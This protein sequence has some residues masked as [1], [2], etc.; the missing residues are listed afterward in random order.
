MSAVDAG[1]STRNSTESAPSPRLPE[2][3]ETFFN[4]SHDMFCVAGTDGYFKLV[5]PAFQRVLGYT[6]V[7]LLSQPF[8]E[9]VY[10]P[11]RAATMEEVE[12]LRTGQSSVMF[13]NRYYH[14]DRHLLWIQWNSTVHSDGLI[15]A[16]ARDVTNQRQ[17][18]ERLKHHTSQLERE[19]EERRQ[20]VHQL[21]DSEERFRQVTGH[22]DEI[23]WLAEPNRESVLYIS[24]AFERILGRPR[25]PV[26][27]DPTKWE[28]YIHPE[29]L[30][31]WKDHLPRHKQGDYDLDFR[32]VRPNGEVRMLNARAFP[33]YDAKGHVHRIVGV[34]KDVTEERILRQALLD[35]TEMEKKHFRSDIHRTI[36]QELPSM[37]LLCGALERQLKE[38]HPKAAELVS[39]LSMQLRDTATTARKLAYGFSPLVV[40]QQTLPEALDDLVAS[41]QEAAPDLRIS[42]NLGQ[43]LDELEGQDI[44]Q[45]YYIV[46]ESVRNAISHGEADQIE[47]SSKL[48]DRN[49]TVTI[50]D[51]GSGKA[52]EVIEANGLGISAMRYRAQIL[53]GTLTIQDRKD[54]QEGLEVVCAFPR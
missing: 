3:F 32:V 46:R 1:S 41:Q 20:L 14:K 54:K 18:E 25:Q 45:V 7:E 38:S 8:M 21:R 30:Q 12:K 13:E 5:N 44:P 33:V 6:E 31:R 23:F 4:M 26:Y 19:A 52:E 9:L 43:S 29:D 28:E 49:L 27:D 15:Y 34:T 51:N 36:C 40:G 22:I 16:V 39:Q 37:A 11:D 10:P 35:S 42:L 48:E 2:A 24:P 17:Q 47:I 53:G 50:R